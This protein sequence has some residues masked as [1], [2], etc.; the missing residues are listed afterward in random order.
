[1]ALPKRNSKGMGG[2]RFRL[3][4]L[5]QELNCL[6]VLLLL[7]CDHLLEKDFV[8]SGAQEISKGGKY[9][10]GMWTAQ[11][12]VRGTPELVQQILW[13]SHHVYAGRAYSRLPLVFSVS[14]LHLR[15]AAMIHTNW[16]SQPAT[17]DLF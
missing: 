1:M 14:L 15:F 11:L 10:S 2:A 12:W 16:P 5:V 9:S 17:T 3:F 6:H 13:T 7:Y 4:Y 8:F